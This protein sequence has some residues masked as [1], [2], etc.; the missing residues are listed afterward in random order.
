MLRQ[1]F[2]LPSV[3]SL[4]SRSLSI[5]SYKKLTSEHADAWQM[6]RLEGARAHARYGELLSRGLSEKDAELILSQ[7]LGH[8]RAEIVEV[9][10]R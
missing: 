6:L 7:E 5:F 9:Y 4:R 1:S 2:S 3:W 10:L 8:F